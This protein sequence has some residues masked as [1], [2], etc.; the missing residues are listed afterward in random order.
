M[1]LAVTEEGLV[2]GTAAVILI[3]AFGAV[4]V[5]IT[6]PVVHQPVQAA[7]RILV[8]VVLAVNNEVAVLRYRVTLAPVPATFLPPWIAVNGKSG[9]ICSEV[10]F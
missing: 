3:R 8:A 2:S 4:Q 1:G 6:Q 5:T 7:A 9:V 10:G